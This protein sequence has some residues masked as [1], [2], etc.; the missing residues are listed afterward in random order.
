MQQLNPE[1]L[2]WAM[3][4]AGLTRAQAAKKLELKKTRNADLEGQFMAFEQGS[5]QPD[6]SILR[7]M[8]QQYHRPL[9]TFYLEKPPRASEY[10]VDFRKASHESSVEQ[11]AWLKVLVREVIARQGIVRNL[12]NE[13]DAVEV[14]FVDTITLSEGKQRALEI[15]RQIIDCGSTVKNRDEILRNYGMLLKN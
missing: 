15:L 3:E 8:A 4:T 12:L 10:G 5:D 13:D 9:I 2:V 1:V 11:D 7:K 14:D 6:P